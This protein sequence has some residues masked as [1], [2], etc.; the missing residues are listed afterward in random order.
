M[1]V[2]GVKKKCLLKTLARCIT[3]SNKN[4]C[5]MSVKMIIAGKQ[6]LSLAQGKFLK[7][8]RDLFP[9]LKCFYIPVLLFTVVE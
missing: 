9:A 1:D 5:S 3:C 6:V 2:L 7:A 8:L 4:R